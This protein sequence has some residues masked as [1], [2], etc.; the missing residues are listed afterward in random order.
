MLG[1]L[2]RRTQLAARYAHAFNKAGQG[3]TFRTADGCM[4]IPGVTLYGRGGGCG[5]I[6]DE[7]YR[8]AETAGFKRVVITAAW[9]AYFEPAPGKPSG[10]TCL[11][12]PRGCDEQAQFAS[13]ADLARAEFALLARAIRRLQ[14]HGVEVVVLG[15]TPQAYAGTPR[16]LYHHTFWT[17][18]LD[19]PPTPRAEVDAWVSPSLDRLR[20]VSAQTG[21]VLVDPLDWFCDRQSCA[22]AENGRTLYKDRGHFRASMMTRPRFAYL[23]P[24]L[25][26]GADQAAPSRLK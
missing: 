15:V 17:H 1:D 23:D 19:P 18:S 6:W 14:Q 26:P 16:K 8:W 10:L 5:A 2:A 12:R 13:T 24:W 11:E 4:P 21:A 7:A 25:A 3:L 22:P 9:P 20:W